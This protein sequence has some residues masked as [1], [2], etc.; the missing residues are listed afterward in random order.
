MPLID[1]L[2]RCRELAMESQDALYSSSTVLEILAILDRGIV[3]LECGG[4]LVGNEL[5]LLFAPTGDLQ[6]TSIANGWADE[7]LLL[8]AEFDRQIE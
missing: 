1:I 3:S 2:K 7:Y 4:Q 8:S 6:E 5:K